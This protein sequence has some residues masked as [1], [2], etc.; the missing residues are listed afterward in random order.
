[1]ATLKTTKMLWGR[2]AQ[3][4]SICRNELVIDSS[5]TDDESLIGDMCHM[6]AE[7]DD[8]PRGDPAFPVDQRDSYGNL[9]LLCRNHHKQVDDQVEEFSVPR[10]NE[11]K[12]AHE[13]WVR[14]QLT[15][16]DP[17][18]Q[19]DDEWYAAT[20]DEWER[21]AQVKN[22]EAWTSWILD[23]RPRMLVEWDEQLFEL[24]R[25]LLS[26]IWPGR[27]RE[28]ENAFRNFLA[29]LNAFHTEFRK[30]ADRRRET[31][32]ELVTQPFYKMGGWNPNYQADLRRY[33]E[34]VQL[35][36]SLV[37]ELTRAANLIIERTREFI[38]P[39]YRDADG[40]LLITHGFDEVLTFYTSLHRYSPEVAAKE[41]PF[42]GYEAFAAQQLERR[43]GDD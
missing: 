28:L 27:Y 4:C 12:A 37:E 24:R 7:S 20:L 13:Q 2:A 15:T 5:E 31:S 10:L 16:F 9:I 32:T 18:K 40:F 23:A 19:K 26:R 39:T 21:R 17:A 1:M 34:H 30:H 14:E 33:E 35:V 43:S 11:I 22:W 36:H 25:W 6:V 29:V 8:G 41:S 42:L 38:D 3:R